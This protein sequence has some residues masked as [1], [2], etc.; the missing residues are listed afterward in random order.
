MQLFDCP[1][2]GGFDST[3]HLAISTDPLVFPLENLDLSQYV[4]LRT[5]WKKYNLFSALN[6]YS[7]INRCPYTAYSENVARQ[8]WFKYDDHE[9]SDI[10]SSVKS[11]VYILIES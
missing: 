3:N 5:T 2:I 1:R 6:H 7:E 10:S 8:Q 4:T 11:L 9:V